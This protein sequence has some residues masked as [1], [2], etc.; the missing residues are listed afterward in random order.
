MLRL[1]SKKM[2]IL[3][4][5]KPFSISLNTLSTASE[6]NC[7]FNLPTAWCAYKPEDIFTGYNEISFDVTI[8]ASGSVMV[9]RSTG[10]MKIAN[11]LTAG[12]HHIIYEPNGEAFDYFSVFSAKGGD[13][14]I[15]VT[16]IVM[17]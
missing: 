3:D 6:L 4:N 15:T 5:G 12:T 9:Y 2:L 17:K 1:N 16:N 7:S 14:T 10:S 11:N 13:N 8:P